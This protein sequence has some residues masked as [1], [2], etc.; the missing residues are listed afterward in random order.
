M[1]NLMMYNHRDSYYFLLN[2]DLIDQF[3]KELSLHFAHY[4]YV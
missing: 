2:D 3:K 1:S 4:V